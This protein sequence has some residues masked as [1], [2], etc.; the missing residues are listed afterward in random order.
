MVGVPSPGIEVEGSEPG[1]AS[2]KAPSRQRTIVVVM[3]QL[4]ALAVIAVVWCAV[5]SRCCTDEGEAAGP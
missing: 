3:A 5:R 2:E 4:V 1:G